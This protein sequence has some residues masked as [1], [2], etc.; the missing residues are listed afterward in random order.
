MYLYTGIPRKTL[1]ILKYAPVIYVYIDTYLFVFTCVYI[2]IC[3]CLVAYILGYPFMEV[4]ELLR[5]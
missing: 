2:Y 1:I 4:P 5:T 3:V